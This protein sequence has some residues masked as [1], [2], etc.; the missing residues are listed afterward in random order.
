VVDVVVAD[1]GGEP[2]QPPRQ[3][4]EGAAVDGGAVEVPLLAVVPV[5]LLELV[6]DVEQPDA[7]RAGVV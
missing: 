6:L 4:V 1:V 3:V 5:G 2:V 7:E